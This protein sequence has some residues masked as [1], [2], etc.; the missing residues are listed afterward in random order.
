MARCHEN[1]KARL[2]R[3]RREMERQRR[4]RFGIPILARAFE[5]FARGL[6]A[7]E[8]AVER[9]TTTGLFIN[10]GAF[11]EPVWERIHVQPEYP[12]H[13]ADFA[14]EIAAFERTLDGGP[15]AALV[16]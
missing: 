3:R 14:G 8:A 4:Q 2:K 15:G 11:D 10:R 1:R 13:L 16:F 9:F 6:R 12:P 7:A 5:T